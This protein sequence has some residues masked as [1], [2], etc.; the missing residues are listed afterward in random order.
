MY[1]WAVT[2]SLLTT[3]KAVYSISKDNS[4]FDVSSHVSSIIQ[5]WSIW[6]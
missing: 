1:C 5:I 2:Q 3:T 4:D 6:M